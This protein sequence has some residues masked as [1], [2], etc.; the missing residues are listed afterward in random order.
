MAYTVGEVARLARVSIRTLHHY[1]EIGLVKPSSR[2]EAGYRLYLE[3]DLQRLQQVLF[4]RELGFTLEEVGRMLADSDRD[5]RRALMAQR[6]LLI[7]RAERMGA[8]VALIDKTLYALER[9]EPM[10]HESLFDGFDPSRY[11]EETHERWG[12]TPEYEQ[13]VRRTRAYTKNDWKTLGDESAAITQAFAEALDAGVAAADPRAMDLAE[14]H[15]QH[16]TRWFYPCSLEVH[17]G[18]GEMYVADARF[19]A[20]YEPVRA[21]LTRYMC[22]AFRA[23]A[24]RASGR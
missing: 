20:N 17:A 2:S 4:Y 8:L 16:I 23:N 15:R 19:A 12:G 1:D 18:L 9:G 5:R 21:G 6:E 3:R 14:R 22:E 10:S 7:S 13:S 11:E 24:A